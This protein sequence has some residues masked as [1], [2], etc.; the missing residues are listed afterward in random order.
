MNAEQRKIRWFLRHS[1]GYY[2]FELDSLDVMD[3]IVLER[4][5]G[6]NQVWLTINLLYAPRIFR[7]TFGLVEEYALW[8]WKRLQKA[9][10]N[11]VTS[12]DRYQK[13]LI[14]FQK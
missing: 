5:P 8:E 10:W 6:N 1:D 11:R 7:R 14:K 4:D 13:V 9:I 2:Q 12:V 3:A